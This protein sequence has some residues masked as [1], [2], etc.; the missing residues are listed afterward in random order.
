MLLTRSTRFT[1]FCTAQTIK[2]R[3]ESGTFFSKCL[4][5]VVHFSKFRVFQGCFPSNVANVD[6]CCRNFGTLLRKWNY[7]YYISKFAETVP[8]LAQHFNEFPKY[9]KLFIFRNEYFIRL[10]SGAVVAGAGLEDVPGVVVE[11]EA[12]AAAH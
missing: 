11:A 6:E 2:F 7:N 1:D 4:E 8:N 12:E 10:L 5:K 9:Q 3:Q